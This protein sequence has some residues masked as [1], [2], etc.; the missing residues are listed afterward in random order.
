MTGSACSKCLQR[1]AY[2]AYV[3]DGWVERGC[4]YKVH[5]VDITA[6]HTAGLFPLCLHV[7]VSKDGP[8]VV[9]IAASRVP[10]CVWEQ[11]MEHGR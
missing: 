11:Y 4:L 2:R 7:E 5:A 3:A 9:A 1:V 8:F 6:P 10:L